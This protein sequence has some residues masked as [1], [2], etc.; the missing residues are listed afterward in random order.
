MIVVIKSNEFV[1]QK[2]GR[3]RRKSYYPIYRLARITRLIVVNQCF[4]SF[5][6]RERPWLIFC[7]SCM[8]KQNGW[9]VRGG[10]GGAAAVV[11]NEAG[12]EDVDA[13][14]QL[15][16][17]QPR[18]ESAQFLLHPLYLLGY[19]LTLAVTSRLTDTLSCSQSTFIVLAV[20]LLRSAGCVT[21]PS[22]PIFL[23]PAVTYLAG[24]LGIL[25]AKFTETSL[26][27][28]DVLPMNSCNNSVP[29]M[30]NSGSRR[31]SAIDHESRVVAARR[32]RTSSAALTSAQASAATSAA[33]SGGS[34]QGNNAPAN[35]KVRRTSLPALLANKKDLVSVSYIFTTILLNDIYITTV[36]SRAS[37][38]SRQ[39]FYCPAVT[40]K[41]PLRSSSPTGERYEVG[42]NNRRKNL[43]WLI[44]FIYLFIFFYFLFCGRRH[45]K[46]WPR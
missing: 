6:R 8:K 21:L 12:H 1:Q 10:G 22:L 19:T 30:N 11:F 5:C 43:H 29:T 37:W 26:I 23:R 28:P 15:A 17:A 34:T 25:V 36:N 33:Q 31:T 46:R 7:V 9:D 41:L 4:V 2:G 18:K 39:S 45:S 20:V 42:V 24:M 27:Q 44:L 13:A 35:N 38:R 40:F 16:M 32:R 3:I 14:V